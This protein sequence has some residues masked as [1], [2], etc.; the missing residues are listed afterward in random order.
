MSS[1]EIDQIIKNDFDKLWKDLW[2]HTETI[3]FRIKKKRNVL[4][5]V[6]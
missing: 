2:I 6:K 3:N 5:V 4:F 1:K